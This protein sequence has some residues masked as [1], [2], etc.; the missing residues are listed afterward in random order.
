M[1][2]PTRSSSAPRGW[3]PRAAASV[4]VGLLGAAAVPFAIAAAQLTDLLD[5]LHAAWAIPAAA[6]AGVAALVLARGARRRFER[7][8]GRVGGAG[9]ARAGRILGVLALALATSGA[10]AVA[11]YY[12]LSRY[13]E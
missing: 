9:A 11:F 8:L 10:I 6:L 13:A 4:I 12:F 1:A 3:N 5:L 7:T 2:A